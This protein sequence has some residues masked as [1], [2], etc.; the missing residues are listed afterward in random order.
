MARQQI[1]ATLG[2][3]F[4]LTAR[5]N[6]PVR[7]WLRALGPVERR[8]IGEEIKTVQLGWPLGMPLVRKMARDLWE[9]RVMLPGRCARVLF[10]VVGDT[11]V[12]LH[13]FIK[14]SRATPPD[15]LE[16]AVAR[17]KA[18]THAI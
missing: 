15:D 4:F 3:R 7:E 1:Q 9:I 17:L 18:L 13:A 10:T 11:M 14:Q 8:A 12:L 16:V 2:V 5:G 6:E